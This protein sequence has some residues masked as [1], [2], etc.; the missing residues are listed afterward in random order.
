MITGPSLGASYPAAYYPVG[1]TV[2]EEVVS[3]APTSQ[4]G[5]AWRSRG[6]RGTPADTGGR[7]FKGSRQ[8][9]EDGVFRDVEDDSQTA[10][11]PTP[12]PTVAEVVE[13]VTAPPKKQGA[14]VVASGITLPNLPPLPV[15]A[16][17]EPDLGAK[18][19]K[20]KADIAQ[21]NAAVLARILPELTE[22]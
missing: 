6:T 14:E 22:W 3:A 21:F 18:A 10:V 16:P 4:P 7:R 2:A 20:R 15:F 1:A 13:A 8:V 9:F 12:E 11:E 19:R 5:G 17:K